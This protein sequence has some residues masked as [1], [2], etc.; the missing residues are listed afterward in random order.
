[1][2]R[3]GGRRGGIRGG[4]GGRGYNNRVGDE[5]H[6]EAEHT[7]EEPEEKK[8]GYVELGN[9]IRGEYRGYI[10]RNRRGYDRER[11]DGSYRGP[12]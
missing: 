4:R 1:M 7:Q 6:N 8:E 12:E 11:E 5:K 10:G 9:R 2:G 3:R